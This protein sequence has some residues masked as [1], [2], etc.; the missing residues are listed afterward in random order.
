MDHWTRSRLRPFEGMCLTDVDLR[1]EQDHLRGL[2]RDAHRAMVGHGMLRGGRGDVVAT[3]DGDRVELEAGAAIDPQGNLLCWPAG[4]RSEPVPERPGRYH[5]SVHHREAPDPRS[6][7]S[8]FAGADLQ[9]SRTLEGFALRF[10]GGELEDGVELGRV[11]VIDGRRIDGAFDARFVRWAVAAEPQP[12]SELRRVAREWVH[13]WLDVLVRAFV[14]EQRP[15]AEPRAALLMQSLVAAELDLLRPSRNADHVAEIVGRLFVRQ[16]EYLRH[17]RRSEEGPAQHLR[18]S[19]SAA[20]TIHAGRPP[21]ERTEARRSWL[22]KALD[23]A[24]RAARIDHEAL[25]TLAF[26]EVDDAD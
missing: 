6:L 16:Y 12:E 18:A 1:D 15:I 23:G 25:L 22:D 8:A 14:A 26:E 5:L 2:G 4:T 10:H 3:A 17:A 7:R 13:L 24:T 11:D 20:K 21:Q 9:A 19:W